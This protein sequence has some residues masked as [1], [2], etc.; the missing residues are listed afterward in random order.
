MNELTSK[1][2]KFLLNATNNI[3]NYVL[4]F[5]IKQINIT[6]NGLYFFIVHLTSL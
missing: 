6:K 2:L 3:T 5:N 4:S 1:T